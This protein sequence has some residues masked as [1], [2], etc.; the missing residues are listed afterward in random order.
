[1]AYQIKSNK[2]FIRLMMK[3]LFSTMKINNISKKNFSILKKLIK[4][5]IIIHIIKF[6]NKDSLK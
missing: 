3:L 4:M 5:I 1:M 2:I 6:E